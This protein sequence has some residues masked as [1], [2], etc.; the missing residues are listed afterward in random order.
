MKIGH[1]DSR[2]V[3]LATGHWPLAPLG[4]PSVSTPQTRRVA[5]ASCQCRLGRLGDWDHK[6]WRGAS[7]TLP[8]VCGA[9]ARAGRHHRGA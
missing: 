5:L 1:A 3:A 2:R 7:P 8:T 6:H 9:V 4:I